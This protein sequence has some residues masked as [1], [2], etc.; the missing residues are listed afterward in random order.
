MEEEKKEEIRRLR[1]EGRS[2]RD[3]CSE[4]KVSPQQIKN[5]LSGPGE[6]S[7][8]EVEDLRAQFEDLKSFVEIV[9]EFEE[10]K[11]EVKNGFGFQD[12]LNEFE[13]KFE[14]RLRDLEL[15][16]DEW[17]RFELKEQTVV[18]EYKIPS[19]V[20]LR[21]LL[22]QMLVKAEIIDA[23]LSVYRP[24]HLYYEED[25]EQFR[26]FLVSVGIKE[27][28][29]HLIVQRFARVQALGKY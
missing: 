18:E 19:A 26:Y 11:F 15:K 23:V 10:L 5:V 3:I 29:A 7:P 9:K 24:N 1:S 20:F 21:K 13:E 17:L 28:K 2:Y 22:S 4:V 8:G 6:I 16:F 14:S 27:A 12:K 25:L